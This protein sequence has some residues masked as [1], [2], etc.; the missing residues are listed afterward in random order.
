MSDGCKHQEE[1]Q[2]D[3]SIWDRAEH[4]QKQGPGQASS[5]SRGAEIQVG[6]EA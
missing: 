4:F 6:K 1:K 5:K 3:E 2:T